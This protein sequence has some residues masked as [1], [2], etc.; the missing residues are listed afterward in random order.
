L[1]LPNIASDSVL[2]GCRADMFRAVKGSDL[3]LDGTASTVNR[4]FA[5]LERAIWIEHGSWDEL[6][7]E[8]VYLLGVCR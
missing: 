2:D 5:I 7:S 4:F 1:R 3:E 8:S 6:I